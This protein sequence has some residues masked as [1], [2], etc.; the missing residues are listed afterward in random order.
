MTTRFIQIH[1]LTPYH[2]SLLNRDDAGFAKRIPF[3]GAVRTRISSQCL[4]RHWRKYD[5]K[6][7]LQGIDGAQMSV[8]SRGTFERF[9]VEPLIKYG[10]AEPIASAIANK[11]QAVVLGQKEK[12]EKKPKPG[13]ADAVDLSKG[14]E[15]AAEE[16]G[17]DSKQVTV[18][19][20]V[21][22]DYLLDLARG[23]AGQ[24][25]V[26]A[27]AQATGKDAG[28]KLSEEITKHLDNKELKKNLEALGRGAEGLDAAVFG[29]M[30]TSDVLSRTDAAVHVAH[31]FTVH[32]EDSESDYFSAI[33]D[34]TADAG[35]L[36]S[37][38][39][40]STELT[41]GLFYG[42][43]CIDVGQLRK[44]LMGV[45]KDGKLYDDD[46]VAQVVRRLIHTIASVSPGAKKG[47][48]A[49]FSRAHCVLVEVGDSQPRSLAN[50]F[51]RPV[52]ERPDVL[53][54]AYAALGNHL[55]EIDA[56]YATGEQRKGAAI[57]PKSNLGLPA[58]AIAGSLAEVA[59][60]AAL[61]T[62]E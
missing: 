12:V 59:D 11:L 60:F 61:A 22:L 28:K 49:P 26:Q 38:H 56:M 20:L 52:S 58:G 31:A 13:K 34:L 15:D 5:G 43:V 39:I 47:S 62:M 9:V 50:A 37:G 40:N 24:P 18:L 54:N 42:Y 36:G 45:L 33:D 2:A 35:E 14:E 4:K 51:L 41:T 23:I 53:A 19:G 32:A 30:V 17:G 57:G 27:A 55:A 21:E 6:E 8:R 29:R 1:T 3:G 46:T 44:N 16:K 25:G 10:V 48:T 7:S